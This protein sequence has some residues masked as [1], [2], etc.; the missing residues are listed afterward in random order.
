VG[1]I[2]IVPHDPAWAG[3]FEREAARLQQALGGLARRIEHVGSTAVIG[4]AAKPVIDIQVCVA[5]LQP[6]SLPGRPKGECRSAQHAGSL[7]SLPGRPTGERRSAQYVGA[8]M[9]PLTEALSTLGYH[10]VALGEI[11]LVYPF[12]Q[13]PAAWP[14][15]HHVHL[16]VEGGEHER[17][18]LAFRDHLRRHAD[19]AADYAALKRRLAAQHDGRTLESRERYSLAKT[20]FVNA[21]LALALRAPARLHR[22]P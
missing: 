16:C 10:F 6:V 5:S 15:T 14:S 8:P 13:K 12:F 22:Q 7:S 2:E 11:D 4:L 19:V 3:M 1:L 21:V 18:H 20:A 9:N 17:R